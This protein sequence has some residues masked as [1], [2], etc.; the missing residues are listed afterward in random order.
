VLG[1]AGLIQLL[2]AR[3]SEEGGQFGAYMEAGFVGESEVE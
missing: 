1:V 3:E 2:W